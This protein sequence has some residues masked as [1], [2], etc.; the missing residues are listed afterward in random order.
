MKNY[1]SMIKEILIFNFNNYTLFVLH[2]IVFYSYKMLF[3]RKFPV[4][5]FSL[6]NPQ[7]HTKESAL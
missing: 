2:I 5:T 7:Y 6:Q 3:K 1:E 4:I